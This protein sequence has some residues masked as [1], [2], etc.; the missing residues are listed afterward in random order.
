MKRIAV[1]VLLMST[2]ATAQQATNNPG[3][4][5]PVDVCSLIAEVG[6]VKLWAGNCTTPG[7]LPLPPGV[8]QKVNPDGSVSVTYPTGMQGPLQNNNPTGLPYTNNSSNQPMTNGNTPP[9]GSSFNTK[10]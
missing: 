4:N 3:K 8:T 10:K 9:T 1:A 7:S 6:G 2:P 5:D